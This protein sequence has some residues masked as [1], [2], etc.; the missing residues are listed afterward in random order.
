M[1][2]SK[3]RQKFLVSPE[4]RSNL[5]P[6]VNN[7]NA[8]PYVEAPS[9]DS[10]AAYPMADNDIESLPPEDYRPIILRPGSEDEPCCRRETTADLR[11]QL[12]QVETAENFS[13]FAQHVLANLGNNQDAWMNTSIHSFLDALGHAATHL[14]HAGRGNQPRQPS[15]KLFAATLYAARFYGT[16][17]FEVWVDELIDEIFVKGKDSARIN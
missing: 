2:N 6:F 9:A 13:R 15:W 16:A 7:S 17:D 5:L 10:S 8:G 11:Q 12:E 14:A 4:R 3:K 1:G